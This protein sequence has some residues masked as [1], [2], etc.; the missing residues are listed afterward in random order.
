MAKTVQAKAGASGKKVKKKGGRLGIQ[1]RM[2]IM[3][4]PVVV[5]R[6]KVLI[7]TD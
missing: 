2:L 7:L 4:L 1:W 3:I 6:L 5:L